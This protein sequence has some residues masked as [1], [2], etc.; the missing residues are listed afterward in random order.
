LKAATGSHFYLGTATA[1]KEDF[2]A[3]F[4]QTETALFSIR[5]A[6]LLLVF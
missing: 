5:V 4:H 3:N 2:I 6:M 1:G